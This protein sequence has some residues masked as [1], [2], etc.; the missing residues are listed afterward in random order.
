MP[1]VRERNRR[2]N[3]EVTIIDVEA[4]MKELTQKEREAGRIGS[5]VLR[6]TVRSKKMCYVKVGSSFIVLD[7]EA[8]AP[9]GDRP[10]S[11]MWSALLPVYIVRDE[12]RFD[13]FPGMNTVITA[14]VLES[15]PTKGTMN[16]GEWVREFG[17]RIERNFQ[18][19]NEELEEW[20]G[21]S[22]GAQ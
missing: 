17:S 15:I 19:W 12:D 1:I 7:D 14:E 21:C 22:P 2:S 8:C 18:N 6:L 5:D 4:F 13:G 20:M 3:V 9:C 10:I 16:F 11:R